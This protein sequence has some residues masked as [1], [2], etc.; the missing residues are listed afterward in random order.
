VTRAS[1]FGGAARPTFVGILLVARL[2]AAAPSEAERLYNEGQTAYDAKRYDDAIA[3]WTRSYELSHL[4]AL[5]FNIAQ[6]YR[7]AGNCEK[8]VESYK[9]LVELDPKSPQRT[10]AEGFVRDL[11]PCPAQIAPPPPPPDVGHV[12]PK[13][14][15]PVVVPVEPRK[16]P[17]LAYA[18]GG[19]GVALIAV[20]AY[21]GSQASSLASDVNTACKA[22]CDFDTIKQKD[23][24]GRSAQSYEYVFLG[25]GL[26]GVAT[27]TVLYMLGHRHE[28]A[29]TVTPVRGGAGLAWTHHW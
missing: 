9:K 3:A 24:D 29:V 5:V 10:A 12:E 21:F 18:V 16:R 11:E 25:V 13:P 20:G 27:G 22:G 7:L 4:P 2:A 19:A 23:A 6:A 17:I 26:A 8:A 1:A 15:P 28:A 14:V